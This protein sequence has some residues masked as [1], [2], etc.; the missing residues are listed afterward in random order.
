MV[1]RD[2][3]TAVKRLAIVRIG[4]IE[5]FFQAKSKTIRQYLEIWNL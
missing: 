2:F 5:K 4:I 3:A 1:C